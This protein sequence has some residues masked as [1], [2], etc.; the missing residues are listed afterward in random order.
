L[1]ENLTSF[2]AL[3][4]YLA[5]HLPSTVTSPANVVA[6]QSQINVPAL[7][8][9][10]PQPHTPV[11]EISKSVSFASVGE[12]SLTGTVLAARRENG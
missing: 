11:P 9:V 5:E 1:N 3:A 7:A 2:V 10:I 4:G 8:P 12:G 6:P